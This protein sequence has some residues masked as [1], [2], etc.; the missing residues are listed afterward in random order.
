MLL[1]T[2]QRFAP[3]AYTASRMKQASFAAPKTALS[4]VSQLRTYFSDGVDES[5][6]CRIEVGSKTIIIRP[7]W[8]HDRHAGFTF[9][10]E[11]GLLEHKCANA[12]K[13]KRFVEREIY[14]DDVRISAA[15]SSRQS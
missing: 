4:Q 13:V 2:V 3:H 5:R 6:D 12:A 8:T 11:K 7:Q 10:F 9:L 14:N 15:R 1:A